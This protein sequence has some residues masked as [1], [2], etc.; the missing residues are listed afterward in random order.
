MKIT[1]FGK[2]LRRKWKERTS[3][4]ITAERIP[5][6]NGEGVLSLGAWRIPVQTRQVLRV[7]GGM[8]LSFF[9]ARVRLAGGCYPLGIAFFCAASAFAPLYAAAAPK[10]SRMTFNCQSVTSMIPRADYRKNTY[11]TEI[12]RN[13]NVIHMTKTGLLFRLPHSRGI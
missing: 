6:Q 10:R 12:Q 8:V 11:T 3:G 4:P 7:V 13:V 1:E 2:K 5:G 9:L